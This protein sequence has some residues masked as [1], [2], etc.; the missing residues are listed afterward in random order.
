MLYGRPVALKKLGRPTRYIL[1]TKQTENAIMINYHN[2]LIYSLVFAGAVASVECS[3]ENAAPTPREES[4]SEFISGL[5]EGV[6]PRASSRTSLPG[7]IFWPKSLNPSS[8]CQNNCSSLGDAA[9]LLHSTLRN[10]GYVQQAWFVSDQAM[11]SNSRQNDLTHVV[12]LTELEQI[13]NNGDTLVNS[14]RWNLNFSGPDINSMTDFVKTL[15]LGAPTGRYRSFLFGFSRSE[16]PLL[17]TGHHWQSS[18][19]KS[20]QDREIARLQSLIRE[21]NRVPLI[22]SLQAVPFDYVCYVFVYEFEVLRGDGSFRFVENSNIS[23]DQHL[24]GAGILQAL[25][26]AS[27][28]R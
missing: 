9:Q 7:K 26:G 23:A 27:T 4:D 6:I 25:T 18:R 10:L 20:A 2:I 3:A 19:K 28:E 16:R 11:L 17:N 22:K 5:K 24:R 21:G 14:K 13:Q 8:N 1:Y 12:V 15:L